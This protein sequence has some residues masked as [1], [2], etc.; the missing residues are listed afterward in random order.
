MPIEPLKKC[1]NYEI[2]PTSWRNMNSSDLMMN[3]ISSN[4]FKWRWTVY[5]LIKK[6]Y[7]GYIKIRVRITKINYEQFLIN[8]LQFPI[9]FWLTTLFIS[10]FWMISWHYL[11]FLQDGMLDGGWSLTTVHSNVV[12]GGWQVNCLI[13]HWGN[14]RAFTLL[15]TP[16]FTLNN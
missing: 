5:K 2:D 8:L 9:L 6:T 15:P 16:I 13:I 10:T 14:K 1:I 12:N 7:P 4:Q 11:W 3:T